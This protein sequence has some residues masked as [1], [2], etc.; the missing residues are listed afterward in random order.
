MTEDEVR[1]AVLETIVTD[2]NQKFW[3]RVVHWLEWAYSDA[4]QQVSND[5]T[6]LEDQRSAKLLD[7]RFYSSE[8]ALHRAAT[9]AD[10]VASTQKIEVN[11]W[12]YTLVRGGGVCLI[13]CYVQSPSDM[14]RPAR[15][16]EQHAAVNTFLRA[17]QL[18]LVTAAI[19]TRRSAA[20]SV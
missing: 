2:T 19:P 3:K 14:T 15:F 1:L 5:A 18:A 13:Q 12:N 20:I 10:L 7:E 8:R 16:R 6:V 11:N 4:F 17:P 9:D